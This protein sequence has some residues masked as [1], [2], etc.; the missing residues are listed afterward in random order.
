M[1]LS[2]YHIVAELKVLVFYEFSLRACLK[3]FLIISNLN[4]YI[5]ESYF[6]V[7]LECYLK[8]YIIID[9]FEAF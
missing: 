4:I 6:A 8:K 1:N 3:I 7:I 9:I 5:M 2:S